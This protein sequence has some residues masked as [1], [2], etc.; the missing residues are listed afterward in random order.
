MVPLTS[1]SY[2]SHD[3][4][5]GC[6]EHTRVALKKQLSDWANDGAPEL[7]TLWLNGMAGT[8]KSAIST[9]FAQNMEDEGLLG[10]TFFIDRQ[11]ADRTDPYRIVQSLA[12]NL[13]ERDT[14][15]LRALWSIL[16]AK[17]TIKD[18]PLREQVQ[19]LIKRPLD[20]TCIETLVIVI[21]GLDEC[22]PSDG[23]QLLSTLVAC[24]NDFPI[25]LLVSSR[26]EP[27]IVRSFSSIRHNP[28]LLQEQPADE[29]AKDVRL[30]WEHS[31]DQLCLLRGAADWRPSV[32]LDRLVQLTGLLFI[33]AST[34]LK[35]VQNTKHDPIG[36]LTEFL[37][38]VS[39]G[40]S[41]TEVHG[42]SLLDDLYLRIVT[43]AV[44]DDDGT[45]SSKYVHRLRAILEVII[46]AR[47]PLTPHALSQLL[48]I[49]AHE[50]H[51]YLTTLNSVLV[52]PDASS[53][54]GVV[55]PL[56]QSFPDFVCQY[57]GQ[58]H[59]DLAIDAATANA[60]FTEH[61]LGRLNKDLRLD[62]CNIRDS[63]LFNNE[64]ED[65]EGRLRTHVPLALRYSCEFWPVHCLSCMPSTDLQ[66]QVPI[67][68]VE[69]CHN[70][71]LHWIEL[72]SLIDG[73]NVIPRVI[74]KLLRA[75]EVTLAIS[76]Q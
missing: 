5:P 71:L 66:Y 74:S 44:S 64:V 53:S 57:S 50:L 38:K 20:G 22:V 10:A 15:R 35:V 17:P 48:N 29:V 43:Q 51:G 52:I 47:R 3:A 60:H 61:C 67:G 65:L 9:T 23:T 45:V 33:Y 58:V 37:A 62:I 31:L 30:Y 54:D 49:D 40:T 2:N 55:R 26:S 8:G 4:R 6:L 42:H 41:L 68:L 24:L 28:I 18:M 1:A 21:D 36:K 76:S 63:S 7:T 16:R 25:K 14:H 11:V 46:F 73:L 32:S 69:F 13:A 39:T 12:Y 27:A 70:H 34:V 59:P 56:H 75:F 19:A 72:L